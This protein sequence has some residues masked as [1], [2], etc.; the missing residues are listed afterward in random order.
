[1]N[2]LLRLVNLVLGIGHDQAVQ[3]FLLVAGVS[4]VRSTFTLLDGAFASDSDLCAGFGFHLLERVS[5]R[6]DEK[7]N[8]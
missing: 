4:C 1:V 7:A 5:T 6:A 3:V 2:E 8:C